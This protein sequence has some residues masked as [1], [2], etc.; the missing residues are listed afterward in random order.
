LIIALC[1]G[2]DVI[3]T[4]AFYTFSIY[5]Q[6]LLVNTVGMSKHDASL[7]SAASLALFGSLPPSVGAISDRI[8][9]RP[10]VRAVGVRGT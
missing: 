4:I 3:G 7:V 9:G 5:M 2:Y 1:P 6:K 8:G 10:V